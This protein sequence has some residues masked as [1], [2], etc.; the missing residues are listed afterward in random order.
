M[1]TGQNTKT[2]QYQSLY[3][4]TFN[5]SCDK[6]ANGTIYVYDKVWIVFLLDLLKLHHQLQMQDGETMLQKQ[7][8]CMSL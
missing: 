8:T 5:Y 6:N 3:S 2:F 1:E 7:L 4:V